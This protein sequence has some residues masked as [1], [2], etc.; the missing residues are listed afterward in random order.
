[1]TPNVVLQPNT[2]LYLVHV[3]GTGSAT[4]GTLYNTSY[5]WL[6]E[7]VSKTITY[8]TTKSEPTTVLP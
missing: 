2:A 6:S 3:V 7:G 4:G 8:S 5:Q 1:M